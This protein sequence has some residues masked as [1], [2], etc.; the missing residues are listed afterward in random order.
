MAS[1][2]IYSSLNSEFEAILWKPVILFTGNFTGGNIYMSNHNRS[3]TYDGNVYEGVGDFLGFSSV[4][5]TSDL[6]AKGVQI[7]LSGIPSDLLSAA[8]SEVTRGTR[9]SLYLGALDSSGDLIVNVDPPSP[10]KFYSGFVD[11]PV[12]DISAEASIITLKTE[13]QLII[14][15]KERIRRYTAEDKHIEFPNDK[16]LDYVTEVQNKDVEWKDGK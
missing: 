1:R 13:N 9:C 3:L 10:I 2:D 15:D 6:E 11:V 4:A 12:I 16:G 14:L 5:E 8:L 7:S